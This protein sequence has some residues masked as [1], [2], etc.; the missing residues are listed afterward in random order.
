MSGQVDLRLDD[1]NVCNLGGYMKKAFYKLFMCYTL[2]RLVIRNVDPHTVLFV[3]ATASSTNDGTTKV[4]PT[5]RH[6]PLCV[7][8]TERCTLHIQRYI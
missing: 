6:G 7:D 8:M 3:T 2:T 5:F 1:Q 4:N